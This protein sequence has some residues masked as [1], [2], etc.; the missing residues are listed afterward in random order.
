MLKIS[1]NLY[2]IP[3]KQSE[4][5]WKHFLEGPYCARYQPFSCWIVEKLSK[6]V[7]ER[8]PGM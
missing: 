5:T 1:N 4:E 6:G 7:L 2:K 8:R 3:T